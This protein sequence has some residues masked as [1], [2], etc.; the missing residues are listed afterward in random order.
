MLLGL[1]TTQLRLQCQCEKKP[2]VELLF[3]L[4]HTAR[5]EWI[6]EIIEYK[7]SFK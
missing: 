1:S 7:E 4:H 3:S 6:A 5:L 2:M